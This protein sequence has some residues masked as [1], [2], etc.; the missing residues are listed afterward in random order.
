MMSDRYICCPHCGRRID[1][2]DSDYVGAARCR[3]CGRW[4][5][6]YADE[7][8]QDELIPANEGPAENIY[9]WL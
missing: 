8:S 7:L 1:F 9:I 4:Y 5:S 6:I 3:C 2:A